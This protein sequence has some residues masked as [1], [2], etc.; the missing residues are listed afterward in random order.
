MSTRGLFFYELKKLCEGKVLLI[1]ICLMALK[2]ATL[3]I[4]SPPQDN[5][6]NTEFY[7]EYSDILY[8]EPTA[9]KE[10]YILD[11]Q[12]RL[13]NIISRKEEIDA[14]YNSDK[15][16]LD[17]YIAYN[18]EYSAAISQQSAF[19]KIYDKYEYFKTLDDKTPWYYY[20]L[21]TAGFLTGYGADILFVLFL[22]V[23]GLRF[24]D[25]DR[26]SGC[27]LSVTSQPIDKIKLSAIR[28][29]AL[30]TFALVG[31]LLSFGADIFMFCQRCGAWALNVPLCGMA[32]FATC[33]YDLTVL[34][35]MLSV[36]FIRTVWSL[37]M[38]VML[39]LVHRLAVNMYASVAISAALIL[40]PMM[41]S[42][43]L[44]E[45]IGTILIGS[46]LTGSA[47]ALT[48]L[49]QSLI[50]AAVTIILLAAAIRLIKNKLP[51]QR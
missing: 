13:A 42:S 1:F 23:F 7:R 10:R 21:D 3:L 22:T 40:L 51:S 19:Q 27:L 44:P 37:A 12:E 6:F 24:W 14:L 34:G 29:A 30:M 17:E 45:P 36:L 41:F 5:G 2:L 20:D 46:Q 8:G 18:E 35:Y 47:I 16:T 49:P 28:A 31:S 11:E 43:Q 48:K 9:E 33:G 25:F 15:I 39:C 32:E 50:A 4:Y 38:C 26:L